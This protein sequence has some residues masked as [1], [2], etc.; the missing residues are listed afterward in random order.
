MLSIIRSNKTQGHIVRTVAAVIKL[1]WSGECK[2]ISSKHLKVVI[3]EQDHLFY[4]MDQ[5]DSHE[6]LIMLIDWLH[7]DLQTLKSHVSNNHVY[8]KDVSLIMFLN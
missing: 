6:F 1:L 2:Y 4:G 5:Q 8:F 3:G 7:S